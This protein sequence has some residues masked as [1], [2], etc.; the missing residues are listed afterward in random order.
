M[1]LKRDSRQRLARGV[2]DDG[3]QP[4][5]LLLGVNDARQTG[6]E[7]GVKKIVNISLGSAQ[8]DYTFTATFMGQRHRLMRFGADGDVDRAW[9]LMLKW[10]KTA[11]AIGLGGIRPPQAA[12]RKAGSPQIDKLMGLG[13]QLQEIEVDLLLKARDHELEGLYRV[14]QLSRVVRF[15]GAIQL[16]GD[17]VRCRGHS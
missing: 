7:N 10:N 12:G 4:Q 9:A 3:G 14:P 13:Q 8:D 17:L 5:R 2:P 11:D 1:L 15:A 6:E 16:I